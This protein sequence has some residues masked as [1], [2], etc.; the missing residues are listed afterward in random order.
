MGRPL[1]RRRLYLSHLLAAT[2]ACAAACNVGTTRYIETTAVNGA[3]DAN[4]P[5]SLDGNQAQQQNITFVT[6]EHI[7]R[8]SPCTSGAPAPRALRRLT[9]KE[10]NATL[11]DLFGNDAAVPQSTNLFNGDPMQYGFDNVQSVLLVANNA[12][13]VIL[14][15]SE[16]VAAYAAA[17]MAKVTNCTDATD[18]C[19]QSF[20]Q[21]F[22][23]KVFRRPLTGDQVEVY[24]ALMASQ[25]SFAVGLQAVVSA[26]L[27]SPYFLY[28][29]ELGVAGSDGTFTL[30]PYEIASELSY[31]ILGSM[32]DTTLMQAAADGNLKTAAQIKAQ[33][34]RLL[35]SPRAHIT[36]QN[37]MSQWLGIALLPNNSRQEGSA[38]LDQN[39]KL[40]MVQEAKLLADDIVFAKNGT[41][42]DLWAADHT[43]ANANLSHFYGL[44][45]PSGTDFVSLPLAGSGRQPGM[46]G[47]GGFI[48]AAS[49]AN[50]GSPTLRGR[51]VRMR[52][53]CDTL[54]SPPAG[55]PPLGDLAG[56]ATLRQRFTSHTTVASCAYCHKL[57]DP[58]GYPFGLYN[59]IGLPVP[60]GLDNGQPI[61]TSGAVNDANG[62][63]SVPLRDLADLSA[64]FVQDTD[65]AA[66]M[67]RHW[68]MYA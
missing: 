25:S 34:T 29:S 53:L 9:Q 15:L 28:R 62:G 7:P 20:I 3:V 48:S 47:L 65:A 35:Q 58:L 37:F 44:S 32:P 19:R 66:C 26:M 5:L 17:N 38:V 8:L 30:T 23:S 67:A 46:L 59:T 13:I 50:Y 63:P 31:L 49:Q 60:G 12:G 42:A 11:S 40:D 14:T 21:G 64:Y 1:W 41:F 39:T 43:F 22:G 10:V 27:Q 52:L 24:R 55:V 33:A 45:G 18:P 4:M 54:G 68:T 61:D 51:T 16:E 36:T 6:S 2:L 57:M 56:N